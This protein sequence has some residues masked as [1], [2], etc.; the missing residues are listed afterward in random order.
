[1]LAE[2]LVGQNFGQS[3]NGKLGEAPDGGKQHPAFNGR[4]K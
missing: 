3:H 2:F 4:E 1:M